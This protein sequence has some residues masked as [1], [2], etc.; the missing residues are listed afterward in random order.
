[1]TAEE[2]RELANIRLRLDAMLARHYAELP[3]S[4][5]GGGT[6]LIYPTQREAESRAGDFRAQ[7]KWTEVV[8]RGEQWEVVILSERTGAT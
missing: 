4:N 6:S 3:A 8:P 2:A 5:A 1:M 7:G